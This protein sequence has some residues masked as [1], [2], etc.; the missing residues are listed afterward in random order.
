MY[1]NLIEN[2][3]LLLGLVAI[4]GTLARMPIRGTFWSTIIMGLILGGIAIAGMRLPLSYSP[5]II[6]DGRSIILSLAG[7]FGGWVTT[8][9]AVVAAG[10]YRGWVGGA[11]VWAGIATILTSGFLG[12]MFRHIYKNRAKD[13]SILRLLIIGFSVHITMLTC[14]LL[15]QPWPNGIVIIK[16]IWLPVLLIFPATTVVM[17]LLLNNEDQRI[18]AREKLKRSEAL[19]RDLVETSQD[20]IWQCDSE[21]C[22]TY[23]NPA[24]EE[25]FGYKISEMLGKK[26]SDFQT[27]EFAARDQKEFTLLM[28]GKTVRGYETIYIGKD[29][30]EIHLVINAK[31]MQGENGKSNGTQGTAYDITDLKQAEQAVVEYNERLEKDVLARTQELVDVQE[32]LLKKERQATFG[33]LAGGVAHELRNPLGVIANAVYYLKLIAPQTDEKILEYLGILERESQI[34]VQ[35]LTDLLNFSSMELGD[36]QPSAV[37][38]LIQAVLEK[39]PLPK[40]IELE[41]KL[42]KTIPL[43]FVDPHQIE[44]AMERLVM[45]A[46][47]SMEGN[48]ILGISVGSSNSQKQSFVTI[49]IKDNGSG[50]SPENMERLFEPLFTTKLRRIGLGLALSRRLVE[51][52]GGRIEAKSKDGKGTTFTLYLPERQED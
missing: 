38:D 11:G 33:Q 18:L 44:H 6:Y 1:L 13:I 49:A 14:Q 5:G 9:I 3:V 36:R 40:R 41:L 28:E 32:T 19:Y 42:P 25:I 16:Q 21:G 37:A 48:G 52:N 4:Y 46:Y 47:E 45:N 22:F 15:V 24:W 26:F 30:R 23:L 50:I 31:S 35:I 34:A 12:L 17:G 43:V 2:I 7:L 39:Q 20:L 29:G 10:V 8:L 27:P 51:V